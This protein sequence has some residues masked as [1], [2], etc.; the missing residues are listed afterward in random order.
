MFEPLRAHAGALAVPD[1][2]ARPVLQRLLEPG[3]NPVMTRGGL[4]LRLAPAGGRMKHFEER[5]EAR[6]HLRG[7]M[8]FRDRNW[9][10]L[11]NLLVW[12]TFPR[13][14]AALNARHFEALVAQRAAGAA[15]RGPAQDAL[16]LLDEGGVIVASCDDELLGLLREWRWKELFWGKRARLR[17]RL[18]FWVFGHALYEKALRPFIG[19]T[20]RGVLLEVEPRLFALPLAEQVADLDS[21][22]AAYLSEP[23]SLAT[24]RELA[25]VPMLGVPGWYQGNGR[26]D[27]YDNEDY[28][29][30]HRLRECRE[31]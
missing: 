18:R 5:Y 30:L 12:L 15:N 10:D 8:V 9:H 7:E 6:I 11:L 24:T 20:G 16:T 14:K 22:L 23:R 4:P 13:A 25:V 19:I 29:R 31:R 21:S 2:P 1:W 28:F 3:E 27:F 26:E 17:S